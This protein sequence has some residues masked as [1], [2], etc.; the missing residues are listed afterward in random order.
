MDSASEPLH[1]DCEHERPEL[2]LET[3]AIGIVADQEMA[4]DSDAVC[5][6]PRVPVPTCRPLVAPRLKIARVRHSISELSNN[7]VTALGRLLPT[8]LCGEESAFQ[9]FSREGRRI[10]NV[11][12]NRSHVLA[13]RIAADELEHQRLLQELRSYC[14]VPD[15]IGGTLLRTRRFFLRVA[16]RDPALHFARV[17]ALDSA[18]CIV[19]SALVKPIVR[20][21]ALVETFGGHRNRCVNEIRRRGASG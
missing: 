16:S 11:Q 6:S 14:P 17:A 13:Y 9:V 4:A 7:Q 12:A 10:S 2:E 20:G 21:S 1:I 19:L 8:L 18:V 5:F 3:N 15:D